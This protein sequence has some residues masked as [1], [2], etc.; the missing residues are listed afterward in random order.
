V[1]GFSFLAETPPLVQDGKA[2]LS[3]AN[4]STKTDY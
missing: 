2:D 3:D 4:F 1:V